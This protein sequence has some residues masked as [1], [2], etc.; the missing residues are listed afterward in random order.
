VA[1]IEGISSLSRLVAAA[2]FF[3]GAHSASNLCSL[4]VRRMLRRWLSG[5]SLGLLPMG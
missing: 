5:V 4:S 2:R 3:L 1:T